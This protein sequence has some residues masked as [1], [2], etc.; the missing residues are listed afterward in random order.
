[1]FGYGTPYDPDLELYTLFHSKF[2]TADDD[3]YTNYP[4]TDGRDDRRR[5]STAS[6]RPSTPRRASGCSP[7]C[8]PSTRATRAG[9]GSCACATSSRSPSASSGVDPQVE[10]HAHGFSRGTSWNLEDWTLGAAR[11]DRARPA[12]ARG[13][14]ADPAGRRPRRRS[15]SPRSR[16]SIRSTRTSAPRRNV[17]PERRAEIAQAWGFDQ[18]LPER[19]GRWIANVAQGDLG[20]SVVAGGQPVA[21]E[22]LARTGASL[23]LIGGALALVLVG[24]LVFGIARGR[25]SRHGRRLADPRAVVLQHRRAVVLARAAGAVRVLDRARLAARGRP[26]GS[27]LRGRRRRR[28]RAPDPADARARADAVRVVHAVRAQ[29]AARGAARRPRAVRA[30]A[31]DRRGRGAAAP[32]AAD[33]A[34]PVRDA[35]RH[36]PGRAGRRH[37]PDR[38]HLRLA[39]PRAARARRGARRGHPD[40]RRRSR[41]RPR[42]WSCSATCWPT[43]P[44]ACSTRG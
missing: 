31:G 29:H 16:P 24:G 1:M 19:F 5:C 8:R 4:R 10:P 28:R 39:R 18:S 38:E 43:S 7:T 40:D 42:S 3:P 27:A 30:R 11:D 34:D 15:C 9:C 23:A 25:A 33:R 41:W 35:R 22:I 21:G 17:S 20:N 37:D 44:T 6:A 12:Q 36:A 32:R 26:V 13:A 14:A 2:A